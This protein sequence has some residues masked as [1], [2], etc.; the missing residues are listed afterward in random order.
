MLSAYSEAPEG[1]SW[2]VDEYITKSDLPEGLLPIVQRRAHRLAPGSTGRFQH[3][4]AA[5]V[6][7]FTAPLSW[8]F[9]LCCSTVSNNRNSKRRLSQGFPLFGAK[10]EQTKN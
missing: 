1:I 5:A 3:R 9:V 8:Q 2:L 7:S 10:V 4:E 6:R